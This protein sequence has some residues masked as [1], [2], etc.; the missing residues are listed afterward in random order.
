MTTFR[1]TTLLQLVL[2]ASTFLSAVSEVLS[3]L[4][5]SLFLRSEITRLSVFGE[6][7]ISV[8]ELPG[9]VQLDL[10]SAVGLGHTKALF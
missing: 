1:S 7:R 4:V 2:A 6:A 8:T 9:A 3:T 5:G 10:D